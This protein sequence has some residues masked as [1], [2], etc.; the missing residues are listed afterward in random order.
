MTDNKIDKIIYKP[1]CGKCGYPINTNEYEEI[2]YQNIY[3]KPTKKMP[4]IKVGT[5]INPDRCVHCGALFGAIEIAMPK[6]LQD[7]FIN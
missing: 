4:A 6:E 7:T 1:H 5:I 2:T 3:E